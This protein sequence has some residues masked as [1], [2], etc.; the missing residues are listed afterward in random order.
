MLGRRD[1]LAVV[2]IDHAQ[3]RHLRHAAHLVEGAAGG[4]VDQPL[5]A[6]VPQEL[7]QRDLVV[8]GQAER[9]RDLAL[10]DL[11]GMAGL[12]LARE[13]ARA[14]GGTIEIESEPGRG[15]AFVVRLPLADPP[16]A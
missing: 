15:T 6:H 13:I 16:V 2:D 11:A 4:A 9:A 7:L 1:H 5:V 10:A 3:H 14:H 12:A 8:P